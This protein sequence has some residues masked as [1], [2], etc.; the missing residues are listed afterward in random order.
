[1]VID[2]I[3]HA[4]SR[5][6]KNGCCEKFMIIENKTLD[7]ERALYNLT[8]AAVTNCIFDGPADGESALKECRN[9]Q[10]RDCKL[11]LRYPLWHGINLRV[12]NCTF[13]DTARAAMWYDD[14]AAFDR[15]KFDGIKAFRECKN[16]ILNNCEANSPEFGWKC[17]FLQIN[18]GEYVSE[19]FALMSKFVSL[20][21]VKFKGK[22]SFQY[23][24]NAE[25]ND[26][27]LD[28]KDAFWHAKNVVVRNCVVKGEYLAWFSE[29]VTFIN[30]KI[31]GTQPLCYCKN[32]KLID[33]EMTDCDL[34]F[35][36]S[37]VEATINGK[38]T[39]VKNP[40]KGSIVADEI[41]EIVLEQSIMSTDC[42]IT[43]RKKQ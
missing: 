1:M 29:N 43:T 23:V 14:H 42:T 27:V 7:E 4:G 39:S 2:M 22:Y 33:C 13:A 20:N 10:A 35:E 26:S 38:I 12:E 34:S 31:I 11:A 32:L 25:I 28:T 19:Y 36:Y 17:D 18:G 24:Q 6:N 15:C 16:I 40:A 9:I 41:G 30:C 37:E 8:D 3:P 21:G 5:K